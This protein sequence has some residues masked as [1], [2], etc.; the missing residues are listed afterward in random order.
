M[1]I[2]LVGRKKPCLANFGLAQVG[3]VVNM[4]TAMERFKKLIRN[5]QYSNSDNSKRLSVLAQILSFL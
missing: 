5:S 2:H 1:S 4:K 3:R